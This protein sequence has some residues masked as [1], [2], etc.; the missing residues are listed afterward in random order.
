MAVMDALNSGSRHTLLD[1]LAE[2]SLI[3]TIGGQLSDSSF[4][5]RVWLAF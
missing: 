3:E 5:Q 4:F 1:I 2:R